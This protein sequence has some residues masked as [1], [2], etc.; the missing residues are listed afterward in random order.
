MSLPQSVTHQCGV[1]AFDGEVL[2][3][4]L[5]DLLVLVQLL[6]EVGVGEVQHH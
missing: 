6:L 2:L 4:D 1:D 3:V 5:V